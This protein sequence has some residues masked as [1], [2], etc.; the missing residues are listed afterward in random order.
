VINAIMAIMVIVCAQCVI[1]MLEQLRRYVIK[2][3]ALAFAVLILLANVVMNARLGSTT[4]QT[5][6]VSLIIFN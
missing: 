4:F 5:V 2:T 1:V 3:M 6:Y